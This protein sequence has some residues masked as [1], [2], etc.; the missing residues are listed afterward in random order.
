MSEA[1]PRNGI[2]GTWD[3]LVGPG[4]PAN[5]TALI[6]ASSLFGA[7]LAALRLSA[8]KMS[9]LHIVIGIAIAFDVIGGAVCNSTTT[10]RRWYHRPGTGWRSHLA[11]VLPHLV[12]VGLVA[13]LFR[14]IP[15]DLFNAGV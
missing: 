8:L 6:V 1:I 13:W 5:E 3:R 2:L 7:L 14:N 15:F 10:T 11:F 12:Y 9:P 4:M